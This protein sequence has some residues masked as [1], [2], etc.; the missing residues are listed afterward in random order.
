[1]V[2]RA[3]RTAPEP[4]EVTAPR[5][6]DWILVA[7][8]AGFPFVGLVLARGDGFSLAGI[9][10]LIWTAQRAPVSA[11]IRRGLRVLGVCVT[12]VMLG[13]FVPALAG[14]PAGGRVG[15]GVATLLRA[16]L[17][18]CLLCAALRHRR[19]SRDWMRS[20]DRLTLTVA[21]AA[22]SLGLWLG[23]LHGS[24]PAHSVVEPVL[25]MTVVYGVFRLHLLHSRAL[26]LLTHASL[27]GL[28]GAL[29]VAGLR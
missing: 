21:A 15:P 2:Q 8:L 23:W 5:L 27:A 1:M 4:E 6:E 13:C 26:P 3:P 24:T 19:S 28:A 29:I 17:V 14:D 11:P 7:V 22:I 9:G 12:L 10:V 18:A 20:A 16:G 25:L